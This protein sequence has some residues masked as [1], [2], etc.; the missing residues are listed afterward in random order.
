MAFTREQRE[1]HHLDGLLPYGVLD[2]D[3]QVA[4]AVLAIR[5]KATD[6]GRYIY[7][8][9]LQDTNETVYYATLL[10]HTY[11]MMPYVYTPTVGQACLDFHR[12]YRQTPRGI[13]LNLTQ[14]GR[15]KEVLS[16]WPQKDIKAIVFTDGVSPK[17]L[18]NACQCL[19]MLVG[20]CVDACPF[21]RSASLDWETSE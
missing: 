14:K 9:T 18:I 8:Q 20:L 10:R 11:E 7:L 19:W 3:A 4:R 17:P 15:V 2:L 13:Y 6:I 21:I 12:I 5:S 1:K 16:N